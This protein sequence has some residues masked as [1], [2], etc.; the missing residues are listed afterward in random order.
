MEAILDK[1][2]EHGLAGIILALVIWYFLKKE[3]KHEEEV[4][5]MR[6]IIAAKDKKIEDL[7][8]ARR[9]DAIETIGFV[10]GVQQKLREL[11]ILITK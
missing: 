6:A 7:N 3:K 11:I 9:D 8:D 1:L 4:K 5:E 2:A 10:N